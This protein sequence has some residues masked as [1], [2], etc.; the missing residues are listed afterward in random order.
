MN[1]VELL[2]PKTAEIC[3]APDTEDKYPFFI[4]LYGRTFENTPCYQIRMNSGVSCLQ[5]VISGSGVIISDKAVYKVES[6][7][8]FM[9][10][11][12]KNQIY[13]SNPDNKFAR[14]WI[15]FNGDLSKSLLDI[16]G[17]S[18]ITVFK[19]TDCSAILSKLLDTCKKY[20]DPKEYKK[21]TAK[22]FFELVQFLSEFKDRSLMIDSKEDEIRK[23]IDLHIM[24]NIKLDD[25]A[26]KFHF[27]KEHIVRS[28]KKSYGITPHRYVIES[29]IRIAMIMLINTNNSI[30]EISTSLGFSDPHHFSASF[31]SLVKMR[32]SAYRKAHKQEL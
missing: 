29:K 31:N 16:Y 25:L 19:N 17:I 13:Y 12:G 11:E 22:V 5:Y 2:Y 21:E 23:Y 9:L 20:S 18:D 27:S 1:L 14:L 4:S 6:G 7:D 30:E 32:P 24:E 3:R 10:L 28:F 15:N 26:E 8:T